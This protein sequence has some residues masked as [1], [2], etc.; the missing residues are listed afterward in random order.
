LKNIQNLK[1]TNSSK[2][3]EG[4]EKLR[5]FFFENENDGDINQTDK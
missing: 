4:V 5:R 2:F 1:D 3:N